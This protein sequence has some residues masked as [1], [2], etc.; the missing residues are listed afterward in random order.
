MLEPVNLLGIEGVVQHNRVCAAVSVRQHAVQG[1]AWG[2]GL[3]S[4]NGNPVVGLNQLIVSLVVES[5][6]QHTLLL[7]VGLVDPGKGLDD[8]G[9]APRNLGSRAACSLL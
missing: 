7:Q 3:Q 5:Q 4:N 9:S 6:R 1:H 8:D 2:E